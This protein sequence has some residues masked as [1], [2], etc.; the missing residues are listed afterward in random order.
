MQLYILILVVIGYGTV[1]Q[2]IA[3]AICKRFPGKTVE[4]ICLLVAIL[5][6][7]ALALP[8]AR[9]VLAK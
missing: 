9:I 4:A 8:V 5:G 7:L 6:A 1:A 3:D 2:K